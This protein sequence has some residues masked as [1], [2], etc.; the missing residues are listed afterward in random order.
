MFFSSNTQIMLIFTPMIEQLNFIDIAII[1]CILYGVMCGLRRGLV[2]EIAGWIALLAGYIGAKLFGG[3]V[4]AWITTFV[5]TESSPA[6]ATPTPQAGELV[7]ELINNPLHLAHTAMSLSKQSWITP[8]AHLL[9]FSL[10]VWMVRAIALAITRMLNWVALG[11]I[12]RL[13]GGIF[14]GLRYLL[15]FSILINV[16][17]FAET[18]ITLPARDQREESR[19]YQPVKGI[20]V[21]ILPEIKRIVDIDPS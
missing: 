16:I 5:A 7:S 1:G 17:E 6:D 12:N 15:L 18:Y 11:G 8:F 4:A 10:I 2:F 21:C 19:V 13:L 3:E 14:G 9:V 20:F